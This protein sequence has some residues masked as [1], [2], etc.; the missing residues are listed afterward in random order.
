MENLSRQSF[1]KRNKAK[2]LPGLVMLFMLFLFL[3]INGLSYQVSEG[4]KELGRLRETIWQQQ[5]QLDT[6]K[7]EMSSLSLNNISVQ[8]KTNSLDKQI[9]EQKQEQESYQ[10]DQAYKQKSYQS[11]IDLWTATDGGYIKPEH[12][13]LCR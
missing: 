1:F 6:L 13:Q 7:Q 9:L 2:I 4:G 3:N 5:L 10:N 8:Q 11:C 12:E